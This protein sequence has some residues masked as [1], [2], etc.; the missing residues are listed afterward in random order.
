MIIG[1]GGQVARYVLSG[2]AGGDNAVEST[3]SR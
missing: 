3:G 1:V 2:A